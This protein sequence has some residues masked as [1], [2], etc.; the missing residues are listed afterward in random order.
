[1]LK[2]I[3]LGA[4]LLASTS[5][6]TFSNFPVPAAMSG[7]AKLVADFI[8]HDKWKGL[9]LSA[10][11]RFVPVQ[12][13]EL[14]LSLPFRPMSRYDGK[15]DKKTGMKNLTFGARYQIIPTVAAFLD[16]TFPTGKDK[17]IFP[18]DGFGFYFG[19]QYSQDF[20]AVAL[21]T[22]A[23]LSMSTQGDDKVKGPM[24]LSLNAELDPNVSPVI[25]PYFGVT[26]NIFLS[27]EKF[28]GHKSAEASSDIGVDPYVGANIKINQMFSFDLC[29]TLG[30]GDEHYLIYT[31]GNT[32]KTLT[33][34][35]SFN[36]TF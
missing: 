35:A 3:I 13:L 12:N 15:S 1:M 31:S 33:L 4:A 26:M 32:K 21:G 6:A 2:K 10:K 17:I 36:A 25:S 9:D 16:V 5:F 28:D 30:L 34:E 14:Y 18:D 8:I 19:G 7:D 20:G 22:E 27:D 29:A 24:T 11:A 23:G